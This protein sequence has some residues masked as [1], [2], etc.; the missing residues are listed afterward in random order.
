MQN[1]RPGQSSVRRA[2][3]TS[4][5]SPGPQMAHH[6][7]MDDVRIGRVN[8]NAANATGILIELEKKRTWQYNPLLYLKIAFIGLDHAL[9]KPAASSA[10]CMDRI[11]SRLAAIPELLQQSVENI[12]VVPQTYHDAARSM[13]VDCRRYID[14][15][16]RTWPTADPDH[17]PARSDDGDQAHQL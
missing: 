13:L 11:F 3:D 9:N 4:V 5:R 17:R 7:N 16:G 6:R 15:I 14:Y 12:H 2:I 10:E 8:D 1:V